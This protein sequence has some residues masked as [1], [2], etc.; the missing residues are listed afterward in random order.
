MNR[1]E[2]TPS[3]SSA[4]TTIVMKKKLDVRVRALRQ[5]HTSEH[6]LMTIRT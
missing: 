1:V 5:W 4:T 6:K 3:K 2:T